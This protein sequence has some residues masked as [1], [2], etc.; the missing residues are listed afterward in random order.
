MAAI[1]EA[2]SRKGLSNYLSA[3]QARADRWRGV[4]RLAKLLAAGGGKS[5]TV[6]T[7]LAD[8]LAGLAPIEDLCGYPGPGLMAAVKERL[9]T[10]DTT[11]LSRLAQRISMALLSN[12]Y[13]DDTSAWLSDDEGDAHA[14][15]ILP[16]GL[17][18]GH[19]RKPYFE[20]PEMNER[21]GHNP[22]YKGHQVKRDGQSALLKM[23]SIK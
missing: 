22:Y 16:P 20:V 23:L 15:D 18:R 17:D 1:I 2:E 14:P 21:A 9:Q 8:E 19:Q 11:G 12:S 3:A 10:G 13:R 4:H 5:P 7:E 6:R